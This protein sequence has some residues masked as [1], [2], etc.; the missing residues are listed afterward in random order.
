V[1]K[2]NQT[3]RRIILG[4]PSAAAK[5]HIIAAAQCL[6]EARVAQVRAERIDPEH[7]S[8][9]RSF[10]RAFEDKLWEASNTY[11]KDIKGLQDEFRARWFVWRA[12]FPISIIAGVTGFE[13]LSTRGRGYF[14]ERAL[15]LWIARAFG[16][17]PFTHIGDVVDRDHTTVIS[18][19]CRADRGLARKGSEFYNLLVDVLDLESENLWASKESFPPAK[20]G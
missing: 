10:Q 12:V 11:R 20:P 14:C 4:P 9:R 15:A 16:E 3:E 13:I 7:Q 17:V 8:Y 2:R 1:A 19:V 5:D 6:H 18:A